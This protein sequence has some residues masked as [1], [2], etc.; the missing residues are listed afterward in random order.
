V[1]SALAD[2]LIVRSQLSVVRCTEKHSAQSIA[3]SV[4]P[5]IQ[6]RYALGAL[7]FAANEVS[8]N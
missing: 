2:L 5:Q 1:N 7:R 4:K 8:L 6:N 3:Q